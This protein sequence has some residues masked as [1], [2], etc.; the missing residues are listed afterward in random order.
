M[1]FVFKTFFLMTTN[2]VL[3]QRA[4]MVREY[5]KKK[6]LSL[7]FKR[8]IITSIYDGNHFAVMQT[9]QDL[10]ASMARHKLVKITYRNVLLYSKYYYALNCITIY[11]VNRCKATKHMFTL[12]EGN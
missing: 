4:A 2:L 6:N 5:K 3:F 12:K 10:I 7:Q 9:H 1:A 11:I 8:T